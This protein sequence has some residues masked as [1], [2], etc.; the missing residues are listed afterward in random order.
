MPQWQIGATLMDNSPRPST[1]GIAG[2]PPR[3]S[4]GLP[5]YNAEEWLTD[6]VDSLL[7]QTFSDFELIICDNASTDATAAICRRYAEQDPRVRYVRNA[8]NIG[9]MRNATQSFELAR[10]EYFRWAAHD[11]LCEP[12]LLERLVEVLD[13]SPDVVVALS[14]SISIDSRGERLP[15][16]FVGKAE[17]EKLWLRRHDRILL[18][19]DRGVHYPVEGTAA[20]PSERFRK[21][22]LTRGPCEA[23]YGLIRSDVLRRT[24]LLRPYTSSDVVM[25]CDLSLHGPFRAIDEPLFYK[26][27]HAANRHKERGPGRMVWSR[28][29]LAETGRVTLPH[30]LELEGYISTVLHGPLTQ[31][32]RIKCGV[33]ILRWVRITWRSLTRDAGFAMVMAAHSRDW[34]RGCYATDRWIETEEPAATGTIDPTPGLTSDGRQPQIGAAPAIGPG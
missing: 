31:T 16:F 11:D 18:T 23:S 2:K 20:R 9:G 34:R 22:I 17:G 29:E 7:A 28:P 13:A 1:A 10:G 25:I 4:I 30:W 6:S 14:P 27:W 5:V 26:R 24:C 32:E 3:V 12:T 19:D 33:S 21:I 8:K 15:S